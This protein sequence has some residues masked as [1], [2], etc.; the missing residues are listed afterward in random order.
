MRK[1][2]VP[3][4]NFIFFPHSGFGL[5]PNFS[6]YFPPFSTKGLFWTWLLMI[7]SYNFLFN[8]LDIFFLLQSTNITDSN[9]EQRF[10]G[11]GGGVS[12]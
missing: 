10:G 4:M 2:N 7:R 9:T 1:K 12:G 6:I 3:N 11:S 5:K 8:A